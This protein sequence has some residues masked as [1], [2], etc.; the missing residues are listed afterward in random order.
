[1]TKK[2]R[3]SRDRGLCVGGDMN[4]TRTEFSRRVIKLIRAI[5]KGKV[6]TY[7]LIARQAGNPRGSR[8]VGWL[9]HSSTQ[10]YDLPW[11]RVI[12]SDG[13]LS[14]PAHSP[15]FQMQKSYLEAEGIIFK[16]GRVNLEHFLW[17][18]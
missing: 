9:L 7:G 5:P 3:P 14:F 11:Q 4:D 6:A 1:M 16:N 2:I 18:N 10:K 12:K 17:E 15:N 8:S 13:S